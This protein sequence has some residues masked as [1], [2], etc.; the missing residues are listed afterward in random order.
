MT[1]DRIT[2]RR[3]RAASWLRALAAGAGLGLVSASCEVDESIVA[4]REDS[5][6]VLHAVL[7]PNG[8]WQTL[9]LERTWD[10]AH[11]LWKYG[12]PLDEPPFTVEYN[13]GNPIVSG[14][15]IPETLAAIDV[16]TPGGQV[17]TAVEP[18]APSGESIGGGVYYLYLNGLSI[19][20]GGRFTIHVR[21]ARGEHLTATTTVPGYLPS[22]PL[23]DA[24]FDRVR[25][26]L[27]IQWKP[28][29]RARAY[30]VVVENPYATIRLFTESTTVRFTG[31]LRNVQAAGLPHAFLPGFAQA[32]SVH[33]VDANYYDYYR[34]ANDG[35]AGPGIPSQVSGGFGVFG[36]AVPIARRKV[37]VTG[38]FTTPVEGRYRFLGSREDSLRTLVVGLTLHV[39]GDAAGGRAAVSGGFRARP[40]ALFPL[41]VQ[42]SVGAFVGQQWRDSLRVAFLSRQRI[43]DT[44]EV[45]TGRFAGDTLVGRYRVR[46]GTW[47]F[48][49]EH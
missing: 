15:G 13:P 34:G 26:T 4:P 37:Q 35:L 2:R 8:L 14:A 45:F 48:L 19:A 20:A 28:V 11:S 42:D 18:R 32:V 7:S 24:A 36:A 40:F 33:A 30:Q 5:Q 25:D 29:A 38:A 47:R 43:A 21:T 44:I 41:Y 3:G 46:T 9:L 39:L 23:L 49:R 16:T 12:L 22:V 17:I 31:A 10:G 27:R 6:V 1:S